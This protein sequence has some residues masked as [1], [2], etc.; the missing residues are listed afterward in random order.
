MT[1]F[2]I[3]LVVIWVVALATLVMASVDL[4][5][6]AAGDFFVGDLA[7]PW[8]RQFNLDFSGHLLL[9]AIWIFYREPSALARPIFAALAVVGGGAFSFAYIL[10]AT[11]RSGGDMKRLLLGRHA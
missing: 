9:M 5:I 11:F 7:H 8:R 4:G 6:L 2:R 10:V 1:L 3:A